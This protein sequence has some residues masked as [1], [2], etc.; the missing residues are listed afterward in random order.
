MD[1]G[2]P[3]GWRLKQAGDSIL[4]LVGFGFWDENTARRFDKEFR[5]AV[6]AMSSVS[7]ALLGDASDWNLDDPAVQAILR[8]QNQWVVKAGCR[9][10]AFY[11]GSR[12]MNRLLLYRLA[13]PDTD[14]YNCRVHSQQKQAVD[15][16]AASGFLIAESE[17]SGFFRE[18]GDRG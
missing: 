3:P 8:Q 18:E 16:L 1:M 12:V 2:D 7:W 13:E 4:F 6:S 15:A 5:S 11:T 10:G 14:Q 9:A 17:L